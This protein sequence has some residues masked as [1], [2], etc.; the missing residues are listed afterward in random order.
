MLVAAA[1]IKQAEGYWMVRRGPGR[2]HA[3]MW[4]FPGGKLEEGESFSQALTRELWEELGIRVRVGDR[5]ARA[6]NE[7]IEMHAFAVEIEAGL[8]QLRE[9]D[10]QAVIPR[11]QLG[12]YPMNDLDQQV[13][14]QLPL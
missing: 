9:H 8:P 12:D 7:L 3:G 4:E 10:A 5:L 2:S 14:S 1:V 6:R 11:H 13:V